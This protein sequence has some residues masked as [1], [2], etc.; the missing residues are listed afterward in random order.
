MNMRLAMVAAF[1]FSAT[2]CDA[3]TDVSKPFTATI[4]ADKT[5]A[6]VGE[7]VT[8]SVQATGSFLIGI[9]MHYGDQSPIETRF[10]DGAQSTEQT[11]VH[12]YAEPGAY[13]AS[14][15]VVE[16]NGASKI[17]RVTVTIVEAAAAAQAE[18]AAEAQ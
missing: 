6:A 7:N 8:F 9:D 5:S 3:I 13:E 18:R 17:A 1:A 10:T 14:A 4:T 16:G 11:F 2:A 12:T 15:V